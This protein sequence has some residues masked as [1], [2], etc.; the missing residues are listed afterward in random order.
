VSTLAEQTWIVVPAYREAGRIGAVVDE[1]LEHYPNVVVVDDGSEDGT[2]AEAQSRAAWVLRHAV[3][4]GQGAAI[5]TGLRFALA[6]GA[7]YLVTFDA[8]G[9]HQVEDIGRLLAP[10]ARGEAEFVLG[11]RFLGNAPGIPWTRWLTLKA[12]VLFTRLVSGIALTDAHN[13]LRAF[14]ARGARSIHLTLNRMEHASQIVEQVHASGLPY[15]EEPVSVRYSSDSMAKG[16]T[17]WA[18]VRLA[19]RFVLEKIS[20]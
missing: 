14:T 17:S 4:L 13:G 10:L 9:Q 11:S 18:A 7:A 8:D 20:R 16:Q 2:A 3:N 6:R 1:L 19:A 12:A 15:R 5:E